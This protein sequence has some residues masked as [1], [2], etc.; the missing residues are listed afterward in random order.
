MSGLFGVLS[1]NLEFNGAAVASRMRAA[2]SHR[3]WFVADAYSDESANIHLGRIGIGI[4]NPE[5]QPVFSEDGNV[6]VFMTGEFYQTN[7]IRRGLERK[8]VHFRNGSDIELA[9]RLFQERP[10]QFVENIE[11]IFVL[12]VWDRLRQTFFLINDRFGIYP[13]YYAHFN[14]RLLFTPEAKGICCDGDFRK[15]IDWV[16]LSEYMCFQHLLGEK[17]FFE[18][19]R[20]LPGASILKYSLK[21]D[22]LT[23]KPYWDFLHV[24]MPLDAV[25]FEEATE[26][27]GRL[28]KDSVRKRTEGGYRLGV[29]LSG[30]LDSR[31][32][33]GLIGRERQ[34]VDTITYGMPGSRDV[35][36]AR[37]IASNARA[38]HHYF[39]FNDG[40][41]VLDYATFHLELTEGFHSWIHAHGISTLNDVRRV[42]DVN[43]SGLG[44]AE[45]NWEDEA[46]YQPDD[47]AAFLHSM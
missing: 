33:L 40:K 41:W 10:E 4:F 13:T 25:S 42:I 15:N 43:L 16:A 5:P 30:G 12:A 18:G 8:G 39:P 34:P 9:L 44:G 23:I 31:T 14:G 3:N 22:S 20:I 17:T 29:H 1:G 37:K 47:D 11:G 6:V 27:A 7:G 26:E 35:E 36:Y 2:M 21:T 32:I 45:L 28:L 46:L 38:H 19:L 24:A